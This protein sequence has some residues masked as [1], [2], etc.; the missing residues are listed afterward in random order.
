M[1]HVAAKVNIH[2]YQGAAPSSATLA[3]VTATLSTGTPAP[4]YPSGCTTPTPRPVSIGEKGEAMIFFKKWLEIELNTA[5]NNLEKTPLE[6]RKG[7]EVA[8]YRQR[9][10]NTETAL[11]LFLEFEKSAL[12]LPTSR[13]VH[14]TPQGTH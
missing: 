12:P 14:L 7:I 6:K 5:I 11:K 8:L 3:V 2:V 10:R 9:A 13:D 4:L 1:Q